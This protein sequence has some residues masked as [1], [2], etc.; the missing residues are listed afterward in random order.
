MNNNPNNIFI[1]S[2][3]CVVESFEMLD[4]TA[5]ELK[6][7]TEEY[8]IRLIFKSSYKKANRT[9]VDSFTGVGD[10]KAL[11]W[12]ADIGRKYNLEI[13]TDIHTEE[14]ASLA[15][16]YVDILQI[17]AFLSRQTSLL[18]AAGRT[19]KPVNIKKGQ[20]MAPED[21][22]KAAEKVASTGNKNIMLTERGYS[23]GYHDLIVDMRSLVIMRKFGWPVI[24]DATHSVQRPSQGNISGGQPEFIFPLTKAAVAAGVDGVFFETHPD[25][26]NAKSDSA[27]QLKLSMARELIKNIYEINKASK[28]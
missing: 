7:I 17:P 4:E 21:M 3:P 20:F 19:L 11:T 6:A 13:I 10:E 18:Q 5:R 1:I 22:K 23:F 16:D 15:A 2:G 24:Y 27:T 28:S 8:G 26:E 25:P 9:S 14:E 12:M